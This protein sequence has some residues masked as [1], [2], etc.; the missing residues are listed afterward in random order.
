MGEIQE[1]KKWK[2]N[3]IMIFKKEY[4]YNKIKLYKIKK[5]FTQYSKNTEYNNYFI[6]IIDFKKQ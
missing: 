3:L 4:S 6:R 5:D 1:I 2:S